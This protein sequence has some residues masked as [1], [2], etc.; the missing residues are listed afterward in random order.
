MTESYTCEFCKS[1]FSSKGT[2]Q[3]H[4]KSA[5]KCLAIRHSPTETKSETIE[6]DQEDTSE[7]ADIDLDSVILNDLFPIEKRYEMVCV[8]LTN[9]TV[10]NEC[11]KAMIEQ[12]NEKRLEAVHESDE[13][14]KK[15][16]EMLILI[17]LLRINLVN[18][19]EKYAPHIKQ[20]GELFT[21]FEEE[22]KDLF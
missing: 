13:K 1:T 19:M 5:K 22:I 4:L 7:S 15:I 6:T 11:M 10:K 18:Y 2:L 20:E 16:K 3:V 9:A 17:K 12:L 14:T 21:K 8:K